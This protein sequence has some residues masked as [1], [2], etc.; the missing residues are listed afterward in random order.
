VGIDDLKNVA[1]LQA[2]RNRGLRVDFYE[3]GR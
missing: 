3:R 2:D 1:S